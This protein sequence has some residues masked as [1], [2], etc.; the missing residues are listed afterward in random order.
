MRKWI[1]AACAAGVIG[2]GGVSA[3]PPKAPAATP[4][5]APDPTPKAFVGVWVPVSCQADGAE[6]LADAKMRDAIRLSI[7]NGQHKLYFLTD[8]EKM[9]GK[10][11][12]TAILT[13]DEKAGTFELTM[14]DGF[15]KGEKRHGVFAFD[16]DTMKLCYGPTDQSRPTKFEAPKGSAVFNEVW[17]RAKKK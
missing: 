11:L 14:T 7:E 9:E 3:D 10:R 2:C 15:K 13:A 5:A 1:A 12:S 8:P 16:G 6:Q 4:P 17:T